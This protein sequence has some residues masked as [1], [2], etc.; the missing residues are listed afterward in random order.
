MIFQPF[1]LID[2]APMYD[3]VRLTGT[4]HLTMQNYLVIYHDIRALPP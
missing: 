2:I 3:N 1:Q 4:N